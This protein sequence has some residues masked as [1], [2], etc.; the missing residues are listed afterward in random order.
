VESCTTLTEDYDGRFALL[1]W[2]ERQQ[3]LSQSALAQPALAGGK[4]LTQAA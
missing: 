3:V 1:H 4:P 2:T